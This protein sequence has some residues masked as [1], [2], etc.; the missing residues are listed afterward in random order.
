MTSLTFSV[1]NDKLLEIAFGS[2]HR[3]TKILTLHY[4]TLLN[5]IYHLPRSITEACFNAKQN[6]NQSIKGE[7]TSFEYFSF[8][9]DWA[10]LCTFEIIWGKITTSSTMLFAFVERLCYKGKNRVLEPVG[11]SW[12]LY[13]TSPSHKRLT[14][15]HCYYDVITLFLTAELDSANRKLVK[16]FK[17]IVWFNRWVLR[18]PA[19]CYTHLTAHTSSPSSNKC[20]YS[21]FW[22]CL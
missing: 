4:R 22:M 19:S 9:Y 7:I 15:Y 14:S 18:L 8:W 21:L 16:L 2:G 13:L 20:H 17:R 5:P 10:S 11:S 12:C 3:H 6:F 1:L